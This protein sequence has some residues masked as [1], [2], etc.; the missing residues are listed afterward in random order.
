[1]TLSLPC[2]KLC[3]FYDLLVDFTA[4]KR[5][6]KVQLE[7]LI[8]KLNWECQ[9]IKGGRTFLRRII[10]LKNCLMK[11]RDKTLLSDEFRMDLQWW[12]DFL[13]F[14]NGSVHI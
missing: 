5:A 14:F 7:S 13:P 8:G 1:M 2:D 12:I 10:D 11:Q 9:V 6:S 4:R 3:Q